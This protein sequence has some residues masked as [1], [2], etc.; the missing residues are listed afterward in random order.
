M[1][2]GDVFR[3][4]RFHCLQELHSWLFLNWQRDPVQRLLSWHVWD[5]IRSGFMLELFRWVLLY[6]RN[7]GLPAVRSW[8]IRL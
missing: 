7:D 4:V 3:R 8:H 5:S 6:R 1:R 2:G